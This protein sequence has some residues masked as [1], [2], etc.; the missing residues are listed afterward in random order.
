MISTPL[1]ASGTK[2]QGRV[3]ALRWEGGAL[4]AVERQVQQKVWEEWT[5]Q[6]VD[7]TDWRKGAKEQWEAME[8]AVLRTN[9]FRSGTP[10]HSEITEDQQAE[11]KHQETHPPAGIR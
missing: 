6:P 9:W 3:N 10:H 11:E 2:A 8:K 5:G 7:D 1:I 4:V